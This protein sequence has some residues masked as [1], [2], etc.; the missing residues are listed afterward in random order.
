MTQRESEEYCRNPAE[1]SRVVFDADQLT[2]RKDISRK[3]SSFF[4]REDNVTES[5]IVAAYARFPLEHYYKRLSGYQNPCRVF[6]VANTA[7]LT[8]WT[9]NCKYLN[10]SGKLMAKTNQDVINAFVAVEADDI[11]R[12]ETYDPL[13]AA[14][15]AFASS[16]PGIYL[17]PVGWL[18]ALKGFHESPKKCM[19]CESGIC[20]CGGRT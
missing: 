7:P 15:I 10:A 13:E 9:C 2:L 11:E 18:V 14:A 5:A 20:Q 19:M 4:F 12:V 17:D 1:E 16:T 6:A 3:I 8:L